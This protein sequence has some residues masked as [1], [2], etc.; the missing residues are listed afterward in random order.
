MNA[1]LTVEG[2]G[3]VAKRLVRLCSDGRTLAAVFTRIPGP[4]TILRL[5]GMKNWN[6]C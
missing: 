1:E 3:G 4:V 2:V 5:I 6:G